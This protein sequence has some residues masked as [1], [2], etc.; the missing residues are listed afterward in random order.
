MRIGILGG[1]FN[2]VHVGHLRLALEVLETPLPGDGAYLDRLDLVPSAQP[3]HKPVRGL[4]PFALRRTL[5]ESA[6]R[7][8]PLHVNTLEGEREGPSYTWDT[9]SAY[10]DAYPEARRVFF[11]GGEDFDALAGW[12]RGRALPTLADI[13]MVTRA[14]AE[15]TRFAAIVAQ[16]W[17][18]ARY[19]GT[20]AQRT[21]AQLPCGGIVCYMALP[22]LDVSAS[23]VRR[24]WCAGR[25]VRFLV[26]DA[27]LDV[28]QAHG[29]IV[30]TCWKE[31]ETP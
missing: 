11:V 18:E 2:P 14:T 30:T 6:V 24:A 4:L 23:E 3:P 13:V 20:L 15:Q 27:T 7:G 22:R 21:L 19:A 12:Y 10:K 8:T 25:S 5:L 9:L 29:P 17:P 1:S 28:L 16:H 26:P 31:Q